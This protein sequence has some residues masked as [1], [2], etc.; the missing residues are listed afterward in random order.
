MFWVQIT[1][2]VLSHR[3]VSDAWKQKPQ[4]KEHGPARV[5]VGKGLIFETKSKNM[6]KDASLHHRS[7]NTKSQTS[8]LSLSS[9]LLHESELL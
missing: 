9:P 1:T 3:S 7:E 6:I 4:R 2:V 5:K 8:S